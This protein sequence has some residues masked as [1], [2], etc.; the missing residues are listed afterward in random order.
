VGVGDVADVLGRTGGGVVAVDEG[1]LE[2]VAAK[3]MAEYDDGVIGGTAP[4]FNPK[5]AS[6]KRRGEVVEA[7]PKMKK[8]SVREGSEVF[9]ESGLDVLHHSVAKDQ[10]TSKPLTATLNM[11]DILKNKNSYYKM[12]VVVSDETAAAS[13]AAKSKPKSQKFYFFRAWGRVGCDGIGGS[14]VLTRSKALDA[15]SALKFTTPTLHLTPHTSHLPPYTS[16]LTPHTSHLT[17]HTSH[18]TPL[19][20][21]G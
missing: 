5:F 1:W 12:Q 20:R 16:H 17:P 8:V 19:S 6:L 13:T 14:Q 10:S 15:A 18:L 2:R 3:M 4:S 7:A 9:S 21:S 11:T